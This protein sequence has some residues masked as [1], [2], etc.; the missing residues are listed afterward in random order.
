MLLFDAGRLL[1]IRPVIMSSGGHMP[2]GMVPGMP[3]GGIG[4]PALAGMEAG[5]R[6]FLPFGVAVAA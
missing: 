3:A 1:R 6:G 2:V 4:M 5:T